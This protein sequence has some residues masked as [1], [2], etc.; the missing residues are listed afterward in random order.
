[1]RAGP[2]TTTRYH[3]GNSANGEQ[4][5]VNGKYPYG[6]TVKG[7]S[8]ERPMPVGSFPANAFGLYDMHGNVAEFC[9]DEYDEEIYAWRDGL[10]DNPVVARRNNDRWSESNSRGSRR[11]L[12]GRGK[13]SSFLCSLQ[14]SRDNEW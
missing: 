11:R 5:H 7:P 2:G 1:M 14:A 4:A 3:F 12:L 6:T 8:P 9:H 10:T 13:I